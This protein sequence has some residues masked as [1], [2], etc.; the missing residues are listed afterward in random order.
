MTVR[1]ILSVKGRD[2]AT[3]PPE[4]TIAEAVK[5]L[6]EKKIGAVVISGPD[7]DIA[8]ILSERDIVRALSKHGSGALTHTVE[9]VMTR[10]VATC[11]A[12]ET[13]PALM[14]RMSTGRFRHVPVV[15]HGRLVGIVSVGDVVKHRLEELE[16][17]SQA[18]REYIATA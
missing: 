8:G 18:L 10:K 13:I 11:T 16:S 1:V 17:E 3:I 15:E 5:L 12:E 14:E 9:S 4:A 6:S 2:V 7:Q